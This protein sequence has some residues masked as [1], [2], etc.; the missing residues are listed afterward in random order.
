[1]ITPRGQL[2]RTRDK[3]HG[4]LATYFAVTLV[5]AAGQKPRDL[6]SLSCAALPDS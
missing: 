2:E 1:V 3:C 4:A 6:A 5:K